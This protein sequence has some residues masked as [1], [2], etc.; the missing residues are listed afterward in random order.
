MKI[1][2]EWAGG[3]TRRSAAKP[4]P[5]RVD[6][7]DEC[8]SGGGFEVEQDALPLVPGGPT[9]WGRKRMEGQLFP[10]PPHLF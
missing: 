2:G 4:G 1:E 7:V 5:S 10:R 3:S 8:G 6:R 9:S